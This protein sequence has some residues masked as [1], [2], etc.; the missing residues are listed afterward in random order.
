M[1]FNGLVY[2]L[3]AVDVLLQKVTSGSQYLLKFLIKNLKKN[4]YVSTNNLN[5]TIVNM[6]KKINYQL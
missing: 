5:N 6:V 3:T 1:G 2:K 4:N